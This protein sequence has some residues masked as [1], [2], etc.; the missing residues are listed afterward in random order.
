M[1]VIAEVGKTV[2]ITYHAAKHATGLTDVKAKIYDETRALDPVNFPDVT[3]T[4]IGAT[5]IYYGSFTPDV[6]GTWTVTVDSATK[7]GPDEFTIQV[8]N[9]DLD[10]LGSTLDEV[11]TVVDDLSDPSELI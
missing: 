10:S 8:G 1:Q 7:P 9:Y 3:L 2:D 11:K 6:V 4:E 5:G